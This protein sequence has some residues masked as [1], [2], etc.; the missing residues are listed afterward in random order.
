MSEH[1]GLELSAETASFVDAIEADA[2]RIDAL[3]RAA[4]AKGATA[5]ASKGFFE[6]VGHEAGETRWLDQEGGTF[7]GEV[8]GV[9]RLEE[10]RSGDWVEAWR[11]AGRLGVI[12]IYPPV[13]GPYLKATS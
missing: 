7:A 11:D 3:N 8:A 5:G 13:A 2:A 12:T 9:D 1:Q 6:Y 4:D 10:L